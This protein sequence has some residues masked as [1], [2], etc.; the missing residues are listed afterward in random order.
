MT[1]PIHYR[2]RLAEAFAGELDP[3]QRSS[4]LFDFDPAFV[5]HIQKYLKE[6]KLPAEVV[7][8]KAWINKSQFQPERYDLCTLQWQA[9]V[10]ERDKANTPPP[11]TPQPAPAAPTGEVPE[12][13]RKQ[14]GE[15]DSEYRARMAR[16]VAEK[17]R[18]VG[19]SR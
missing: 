19:G 18:K 16:F 2:D 5:T 11:A 3:W 14:D 9:F 7:D 8:A 1:R 4:Q 15:T 6:R 10:A 17:L 13:F 12:E